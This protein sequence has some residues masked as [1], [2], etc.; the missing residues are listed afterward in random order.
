MEASLQ[1]LGLDAGGPAPSTPVAATAATARLMSSALDAPAEQQPRRPQP[2]GPA[3]ASAPPFSLRMDRSTQV[4]NVL[5]KAI[6]G[7]STLRQS[8]GG[9]SL[10][11][12]I[13]P[14]LMV[15]LYSAILAAMVLRPAFYLR[16]R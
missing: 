1:R 7:V 5:T 2:A 4:A 12:R 13:S 11:V 3:A 14:L 15:L 6:V 8:L 9:V 10:A 16:H